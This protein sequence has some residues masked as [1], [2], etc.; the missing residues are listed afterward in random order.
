ML[1]GMRFANALFLYSLYTEFIFLN[2]TFPCMCV[3][4][5]LNVPANRFPKGVV[6]P[7]V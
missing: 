2:A 3:S 7:R 4:A 6:I 1:G 5:L